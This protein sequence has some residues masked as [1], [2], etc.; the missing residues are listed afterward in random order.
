M[1][2]SHTETPTKLPIYFDW[3]P[4]VTHR[5]TAS[6]LS[7]EV[8]QLAEELSNQIS[9]VVGFD[10]G[11]RATYFTD[12]SDCRHV[13]IRVVVPM[14]L[15]DAIHTVALCHKYKVPITSR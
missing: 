11:S 2:T 3:M 13:P 9:A 5:A 10:N 8:H 12:G 1:T 15:Q 6:E 14:T 7:S 4:T